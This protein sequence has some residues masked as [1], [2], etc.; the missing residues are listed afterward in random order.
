MATFGAG[1]HERRLTAML[2]AGLKRREFIALLGSAAAYPLT[3]RAQ[4]PRKVPR[5][6]YLSAGSPPANQAF[7]QGMREFGYVEDRNILVEYRWAEGNPDRLPELAADLIRLELVAIFAFGTQAAFAAKSVAKTTPVIFHTHADPVEAEFATSLARPGGMLTGLTLMAPQ[8]VG[9][10][11]ALLKEAVPT[12][13][14]V[15]V[16]VN[17]ANPGMQ[18]TLR[19]LQAAAESLELKLQMLEAR[20]PDEVESRLGSMV[21]GRA[22]ALY[23]TL[24]PLFFERR[25]QIV[26]FAAKERLPALYDV[27]PFVEAGGLMS[28]G[29]NFADSF[30]RV[31]FFLDKILKGAKPA[32]LPVEQPT[33]FDLVVNLK[34]ARAFGLTIPPSLLARADEVIE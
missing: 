3:A 7:W 34:T 13:S 33:E 14:S 11:L 29:P 4:Q 17:T 23:V 27:K 18:S 6:G 22:S 2:T 1:Q 8:L 16:V 30:R 9:K 10:R 28:Y 32:D 15:A 20:T 19:H 24:D 21:G 25:K 5:I 31:A 12:A 26:E